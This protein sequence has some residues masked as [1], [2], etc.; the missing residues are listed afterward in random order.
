MQALLQP[1]IARRLLL[2][3][4]VASGLVFA[5]IYFAGRLGVNAPDVGNFDRELRVVADAATRV[6]DGSTDARELA[7]ALK[8]L[9]GY[10]S[11]NQ[12]INGAPEGFV[13]FR[14]TD[15]H[16]VAVAFG[17]AG[18]AQWPQAPAEGRYVRHLSDGEA[19][20]VLSV[21]SAD[22]RFAIDI[23][24]SERSRQS[25]FDDVMSSPQALSPLLYALPILL[26]PAWIAVHRGLKPLR[27]LSAELAARRPD[28]LSPVRVEGVYRE[29]V[30]L[31]RDLNAAFSR[32]GAM[33]ERER[34]FLADAAHELRTPLAVMTAQCDSLRSA[35]SEPA[36]ESALARLDGGLSR[37]SRLVN[38][39]LALARLEAGTAD[40]WA[41]ADVADL[42]RDVLALR[43]GVAHE[44]A[45][46]LSYV[47]PD[48]LVAPC[49]GHCVESILG[50]LVG[51]AIG[52][53]GRGARVEVQLE[54]PAPGQVSLR[55]C[56]DGPGIAAEDRPHIFDRFRRGTGV[57]VTGSGL[58]LAIVKEAARKLGAAVV[59]GQGLGGRGVCI[60]V[61]WS[62]AHPSP[63]RGGGVEQR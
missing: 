55:V 3:L 40:A 27:R 33:L 35:P 39:L 58:G 50:N 9:T 48:H 25:I 45:V 30:P 10:L 46:E 29:L 7:T 49:I 31:I 34:S 17:G 23:A 61:T 2:A 59:V 4:V 53:S 42:T 14:V 19:Y 62:T 1:S 32:I 11:A 36:R 38:Q 18:P 6:A 15:A 41:P 8:G 44:Y 37:A 16:G 51:N 56:D 12:K 26:L 54:A 13:S 52:Y 60:S 57:Q 22:G 21:R 28:D 5:A 43:A 24:S 47:G 63:P 20:R